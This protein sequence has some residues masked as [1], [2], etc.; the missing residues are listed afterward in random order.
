[1]VLREAI[2]SDFDA[3]VR[4]I[5]TLEEL[6][7]VYPKGQHPF[8]AGQL[9][10]LAESRKELTVAV[11]DGEVVG[12]ANLYNV[13]PPNYAF[14]GNV[15]VARPFRGGGIGRSLVSHMIHL[16]FEKY[17][18]DEVRISVF[19]ENTPALLL[20]AGMEFKP[21]AIEERCDPYGKRVGLLH[22]RLGKSGQQT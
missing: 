22:M 21:Y 6:F 14:I 18:V 19:N 16:A 11:E 12:F 2:E 3:I 7:Y 8:S 20:Y 1:M 17:G 5:Q 10:S 4:L 9:R 13:E 15:V